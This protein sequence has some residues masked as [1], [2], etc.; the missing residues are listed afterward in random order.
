MSERYGNLPKY[1]R[2][3]FS[4]VALLEA[5]E[6]AIWAGA[7][8]VSQEVL[9]APVNQPAP[10]NGELMLFKPTSPVIAQGR[11][12]PAGPSGESQRIAPLFGNTGPATVQFTPDVNWTV[13]AVMSPGPATP[14]RR[15]PVGIAFK[16]S[17]ETPCWETNTLNP[18][19]T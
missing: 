5:A 12:A 14:F 9:V 13:A 17:A 3:R 2:L 18:S 8:G 15:A 16:P 11:F 7:Y 6:P 10:G 4:Q 19:M 1:G